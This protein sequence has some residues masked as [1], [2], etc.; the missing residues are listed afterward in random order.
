VKYR[1]DKADDILK[2]VHGDCLWVGVAKEHQVSIHDT[3]LYTDL[4]SFYVVTG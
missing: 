2:C 4:H 3:C 1:A